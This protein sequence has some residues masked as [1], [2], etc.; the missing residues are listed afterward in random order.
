MKPCNAGNRPTQLEGRIAKH[1]NERN[2][3]SVEAEAA[4]VLAEAAWKLEA[5]LAE[6]AGRLRPFPAFLG[7][8]SVQ[9]VELE[10]DFTPIQD[11][12]C[13]VVNPEGQICT[14]GIAGIGGIAGIIETE[15]VEEMTPVDLAPT[16][17][18]LYAGA[19]IEALSRELRR[20][21]G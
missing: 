20:R 12:G 21:G 5:L 18:I 6:L 10:V 4:T 11:L 1:M 17:Y 2:S 7:M 19:A 14:L 3:D 8:T 15:Q 16:E 9:A 13:V